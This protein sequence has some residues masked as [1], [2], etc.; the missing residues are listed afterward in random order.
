MGETSGVALVLVVALVAAGAAALTG[1]Q[2]RRR[3]RAVRL[4]VAAAA[5]Q[6][7]TSLALP[8]S[9]AARAVALVLTLALV[10][11]FLYG[12]RRAGGVPLVATGLLLNGLVIA[13]NGAMP[14]SAA[15]AERAGLSRSELR[16]ETDPLRE[17]ETPKTR[18]AALGDVVPVALPVAPQVVSAGDVLVAA[19]VGLLLLGAGPQPPRRTERSTVLVKDST[20]TGSYS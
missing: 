20:T 4:L 12:N 14:V 2:R 11:L 19:G 13:V 3:W 9:G 17:P 7:A 10:G 8:E 6:F 5:V 15:A 1:G 18:L 16:L